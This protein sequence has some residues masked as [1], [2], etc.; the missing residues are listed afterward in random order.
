LRRT[1]PK[2]EPATFSTVRGLQKES[3]DTQDKNGSLCIATWSL[4]ESPL[5]VRSELLPLLSGFEQFLIAY[6]RKFGEVNNVEYFERFQKA[7]PSVSW[8]TNEIAHD[9]DNYY[10]IGRQM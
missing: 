3:E 1:A 2:P 6:Q 7:L 8:R 9:R 4:S 5:Q 10:L